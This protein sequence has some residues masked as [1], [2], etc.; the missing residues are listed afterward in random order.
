MMAQAKKSPTYVL[1]YAA[2]VSTL[3]TAGIMALHAATRDIVERN[4]RL[5]EQKAIVELFGLGDVETLS[6]TEIVELYENRAYLF[7]DVVDPETG[8]SHKVYVAVDEKNHLI[9]YAFSVSGTGFWARID[10]Y[11]AVTP[12]L[13]KVMGITFLQHQ[14]TPGLGGRITERT[15]RQKFVGLNV[16]PNPDGQFIYIG[17]QAPQADS[18]RASRH[19]DAISGATG[20]ITALDRFL[21]EQIPMF[22]RLEE[23]LLSK[24]VTKIPF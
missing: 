3:F 22:R 21:N 2:V 7:D 10:G 23:E 1:L 16:S 24:H 17:G 19:V 15:W 11:M 13:N 4:E 6:D 20:T 12:D 8:Q 18:P 5:F 14:E 9:G